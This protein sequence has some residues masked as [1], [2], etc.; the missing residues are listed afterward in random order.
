MNKKVVSGV[1]VASTLLLASPF[2][3]SC[4]SELSMQEYDELQ[5]DLTN[6]E[7]E[8][9]EL[10]AEA[11]RLE[12]EANRLAGELNETRTRNAEALAYARFLDRLLSL[13]TSELV[14]SG[15]FDVET[16]TDAAPE[17]IAAAEELHD[18]DVIYYLELIKPDNEDQAVAAYYKAIECC[19]KKIKQNLEG[20]P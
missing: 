7:A 13:Q 6:M 3:S 4:A 19:M 14:I 9:N 8:R 5:E 16:L 17:L 10:W 20:K 11:N 15:E 2:F 12:A 1:L 18:P